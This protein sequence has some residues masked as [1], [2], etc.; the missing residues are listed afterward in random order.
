MARSCKTFWSTVCG[1]RVR[2]S[3]RVLTIIEHMRVERLPR[4]VP[5]SLRGEALQ[6]MLGQWCKLVRHFEN[7]T[8]PISNNVCE[9]A[10][11]PFV[12]GRRDRLFADTVAGAQASANLYS[13]VES[14]NANRVA[15]YRYPV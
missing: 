9:N 2:D 10:L 5:L 14:C 8:W 1:L 4:A 13:L 12:V 15:P 7:W 6:Y 11:S 3:S